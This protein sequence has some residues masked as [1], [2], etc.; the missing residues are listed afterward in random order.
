[1][2]EQHL[3]VADLAERY[4]VPTGT[5]YRWNYQGTGPRP[6]K[7]G[8]HCRYRLRDVEAW[9]ERRAADRKAS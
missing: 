2:P 9:E 7:V 5:I 6:I 8:K 3:T 4:R 1:M